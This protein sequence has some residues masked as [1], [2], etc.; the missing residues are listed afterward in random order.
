MIIK[1]NIIIPNWANNKNL[2]CGFTLPFYGNQALTRN[3]FLSGRTT[4]DNRRFLF[5][6]LNI[7]QK[8]VF[9]LHQIHSDKIINVRT[10]LKG[11]GSVSLQN[12]L[13]GDSCF[14]TDKNILLIVTW[15]DCIPVLLYE[16]TTGFVA[17]VHSGWRGTDNN[18]VTKTINFII[19][20]GGNVNDIYASIGPGIKSCCFEVKED[21]LNIFQYEYNEKYYVSNKD[22]YF[23]NL[24]LKVYDEILQS[25]VNPKNIDYINLCT[26]CNPHP[27]FF[28]CRKM[29]KENFEAQAAFIGIFDK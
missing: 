18:I 9:S 8:D 20:Y 25:G 16:K 6:Y 15:A 11:K 26:A 24:S 17:A 27:S 28:S 21:F 19:K 4:E 13:D 3:S 7:D 22:K 23:F 14:T 1:D 5:N 29:G 10:N 12:A 2:K